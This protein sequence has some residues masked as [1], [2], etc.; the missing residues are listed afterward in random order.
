MSITKELAKKKLDFYLD[1]EEKVA[2]KKSISFNGRTYTMQDLPMITDRIDYWER[3]L[4]NA[5][6]G[7]ASHS[8]VR[9]A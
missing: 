1:L 3:R 2:G 4:V 7:G 8:L 9:F 6:S 5:K